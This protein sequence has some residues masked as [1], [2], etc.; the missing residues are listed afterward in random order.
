MEVAGG[1]SVLK[2]PRAEEHHFDMHGRKRGRGKDEVASTDAVG[3]NCDFTM[4]ITYFLYE[5]ERATLPCQPDS[6]INPEAEKMFAS[7][8][9]TGKPK[10][11]ASRVLHLRTANSPLSQIAATNTSHALS[12]L[13]QCRPLACRTNENGEKSTFLPR[14]THPSCRR[15]SVRRAV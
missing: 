12:P 6:A 10:E 1:P 5:R 2:L 8:S 4:N 14:V 15:Q 7:R 3:R 9:L 13:E 11:Y